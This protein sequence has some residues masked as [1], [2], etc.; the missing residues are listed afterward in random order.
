VATVD[1]PGSVSRLI[2]MA[3]RKSVSAEWSQRQFTVRDDCR[4]SNRDPTLAHA[5]CSPIPRVAG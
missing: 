2:A 4:P 1:R 5:Q 3:G